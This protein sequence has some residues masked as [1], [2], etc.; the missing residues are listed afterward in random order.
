MAIIRILQYPDPRLKLVASPVE[1]FTAE[2]KQEIADMCE[3]YFAQENCAALAHSQMDFA[4]P[5]RITVI[6]SSG[7]KNELLC[8]VNPE[9][10]EREGET[11][12]PE[13][14][15]SVAVTS[16]VTARVKRSQKIRVK[17]LDREGNPL[18]FEADGFLAKCIQHELDHLDGILYIDKISDFKRRQLEKKIKRHQQ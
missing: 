5:K 4:H 13:G 18:D 3:T 17:A 12:T 14:C 11:N 9:I 6:D 15:M 2:V 10:I 8:L 7:E 1:E 16:G